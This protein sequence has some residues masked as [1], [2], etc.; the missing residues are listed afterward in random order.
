MLIVG[1]VTLTDTKQ[2]DPKVADT[3]LEKRDDGILDELGQQF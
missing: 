1:C 3:Q 2:V